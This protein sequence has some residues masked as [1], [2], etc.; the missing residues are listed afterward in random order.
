M[1]VVFCFFVLFYFKT[2]KT[3]KNALIFIYVHLCYVFTSRT[4]I[5]RE[6]GSNPYSPPS[7]A[8]YG[9]ANGT[10]ENRRM[11]IINF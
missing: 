10:K 5:T 6:R 7:S 4:N 3:K 9:L 8:G 2:K 1:S 11:K